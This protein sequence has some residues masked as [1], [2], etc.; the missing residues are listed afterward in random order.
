MKQSGVPI[1]SLCKCHTQEIFVKDNISY[2]AC[3][4]CGFRFSQPDGNPNFETTYDK[5]EDGYK[6]YLRKQ[7]KESHTFKRYLKWIESFIKL[8][9]NRSLLEIGCGSGA[10]FSFVEKNRK[11]S[12]T[13]LEPSPSIYSEF[14]LRTKN[15]HC[16]TLNEFIKTG[17]QPFN[18]VVF[19]EMLEHLDKDSIPEFFCDLEKMTQ[20]GSYIFFS[21]PATDSAVARIMGKYWHQYQ[22]YHLSF[23]NEKCLSDYLENTPFRILDSRA[24]SRTVSV[25]YVLNYFLN[26]ILKLNKKVRT[27]EDLFFPYN[28]YDLSWIALKRVR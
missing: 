15:I 3:T 26:F 8:D 2:F 25:N 23:F 24:I 7:S 16:M 4:C 9:E 10:F 22:K 28:I 21:I 18:V 17:H 14:N 19:F 6:V 1:C 27:G 5:L 13:G 11:I 20:I 12:M